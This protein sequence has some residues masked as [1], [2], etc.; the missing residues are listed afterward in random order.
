MRVII[1]KLFK[2]F[3]VLIISSC[4][5]N[6]SKMKD[7]YRYNFPILNR[8]E[9]KH[10]IHNDIRLDNYY[11]LKERENLDVIDYL[12]KEN[13]Y[14]RKMTKKDMIF[15]K[16]L[17]GEMK[18]RIKENDTSVPYLYNN[19]WYITRYEKGK[20]YPVYIRKKETLDSKEEILFDCNLM[21]KGHEYFSLIDLCTIDLKAKDAFGWYHC[22]QCT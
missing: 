16:S 2:L 14:Y 17:F 18:S 7:S 4:V 5:K 15:K 6:E 21:A 9:Y 22:N 12:E 19:Y 11:W 3:C 13:S 1:K 10:K 20:E 8:I